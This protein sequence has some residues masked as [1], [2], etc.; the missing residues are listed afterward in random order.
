MPNVVKNMMVREL[1]DELKDADGMLLIS[2]G[3]LTVEETEE[4]RNK[5]AEQDVPLR[6]V[7]NR[8]TRIALKERG[9]DAPDDLLKGN[10]GISW[11]DAEAAI[12]AAKVVKEAPAKKDGRLGYRGGLMEGNLLGA[13]D[14]AL[15]ANMPGRDELRAMILGCLSGPA[16]GIVQCLAGVPGGLAR[17]IQARVDE[18]GDSPTEGEG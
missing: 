15:L 14:A 12:H 1:T 6:M 3:G 5:L 16:R 13:E 18:A 9:I 10:V 11:G 2:M 7:P 17:V 4:L 8:L